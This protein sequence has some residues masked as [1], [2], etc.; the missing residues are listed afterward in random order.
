MNY[1]QDDKS[2]LH[3]YLCHGQISII[4]AKPGPFHLPHS[5][6]ITETKIF[7]HQEAKH[8]ETQIYFPKDGI[9]KQDGLRWRGKVIGVKKKGRNWL[10]AHAR[11]TSRLFI[12]HMLRNRE[13]ALRVKFWTCGVKGYPSDTCTGPSEGSVTATNLSYFQISEKHLRQPLP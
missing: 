7:I 3:Y 5:L 10:S 9:E 6:L 4:V 11:Q 2:K 12:E 13:H 1:R 8:E